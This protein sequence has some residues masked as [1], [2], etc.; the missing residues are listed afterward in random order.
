MSSLTKILTIRSPRPDRLQS[1][2]KEVRNSGITE[3]SCIPGPT[4]NDWGNIRSIKMQ[5]MMNIISSPI[6]KSI[7]YGLKF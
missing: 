2:S 1:M 6:I 7:Q 3:F 5:F 4:A